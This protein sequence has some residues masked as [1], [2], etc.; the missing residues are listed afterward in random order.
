MSDDCSPNPGVPTSL[1]GL[2]DVNPNI[3][4]CIVVINK[5]LQIKDWLLVSLE[6]DEKSLQ[7]NKLCD[8]D[9]FQE[10]MG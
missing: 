5:E 4:W 3:W 9:V 6:V 2:F 7:L 10:F 8:P 1:G